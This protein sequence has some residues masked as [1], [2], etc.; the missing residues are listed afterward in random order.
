MDNL[1]VSPT[2]SVGPELPQRRGTVFFSFHSSLEWPPSSPGLWESGGPEFESCQ[3]G[4]GET[5][6]TG[7]WRWTLVRSETERTGVCRPGTGPSASLKSSLLHIKWAGT[8]HIFIL[9]MQQPK[10]IK[11]PAYLKANGLFCSIPP[12]SKQTN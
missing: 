12:P 9:Q 5:P 1:S 2:T 11:Q 10:A 8:V 6:L 4:L 7:G 3:V